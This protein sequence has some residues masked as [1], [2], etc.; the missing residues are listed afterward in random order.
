M[1]ASPPPL[2]PVLQRE[3]KARRLTLEQLA[4]LSGISKSMLSQIERGQVNP[5]F[6][7]LWS[8]TQALGIALSDLVQTGEASGGKDDIEVLGA[9]LT[10]EIRSAD[11]RCRLRILSVPRRAGEIEWY[12]VEMRPGGRLDSA[13]HTRGSFEHFT[14]LTDGFEITSGKGAVTLSAGET[15]RYAADVPHSISN[16]SEQDARGFLVLLYS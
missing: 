15:A 5:T 1:T 2:G 14:A 6:A 7:V 16:T 13:P 11:G 12:Q 9:A 8:L 4:A 3:R 10:P